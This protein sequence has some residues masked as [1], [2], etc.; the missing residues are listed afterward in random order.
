MYDSIYKTAKYEHHDTK[1]KDAN[2]LQH[3]TAREDAMLKI[4][5]KVKLSSTK[6]KN[7]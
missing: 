4:K 3:P 7:K 2:S 5:R 1:N 6:K